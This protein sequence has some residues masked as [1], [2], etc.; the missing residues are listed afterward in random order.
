MFPDLFRRALAERFD[1]VGPLDGQIETFIDALSAADAKE[2]RAIVTSA[3]ATIGART[4]EALPALGVI[5]CRGSGYDSVDMAAARAR[6]IAVTNAPGLS[7]S[8]V[9][10][11]AMGLLLAS[12]RNMVAGRQALEQGLW[13]DDTIHTNLRVR[14]LT[15]CRLGVFGLGAIGGKIAQRAQAFEMEIGYHNRT[16]RA[17]TPYRYFATLLDLADWADVLMVAVRASAE[18][19]HSINADVLAALGKG[20]YVINVSRGS[21]VDE[22]ALVQALSSGAIGGAGLDVFEH[23][24]AVPPALLA[25]PNVAV[26]PHMGADT[27]AV[28]TQALR[29]VMDNLAAFFA[30]RP[31]LTPVY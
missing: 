14:G 15:G 28:Q 30:N 17:G 9:A 16:S 12:A 1:V 11:L 19:R 25:M 21:V 10:D 4:M 22:R 31:L 6:G 29:L 20:G 13:R 2:I 18:N 26:T 23:E 3:S 27:E 8:S 24:P 5:C 7:S